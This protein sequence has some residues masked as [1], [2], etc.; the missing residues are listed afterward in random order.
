M[1]ITF[2]YTDTTFAHCSHHFCSKI[3]PFLKIKWSKAEAVSKTHQFKEK[4]S[5]FLSHLLRDCGPVRLN[6]LLHLTIIYLN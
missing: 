3:T 4:S 5:H 6:A 1:T 2:L